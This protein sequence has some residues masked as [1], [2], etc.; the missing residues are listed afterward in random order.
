MVSTIQ[1]PEIDNGAIPTMKA[2]FGLLCKYKTCTEEGICLR[3]HVQHIKIIKASSRDKVSAWICKQVRLKPACT[4]KE[5]RSEKD[6][7]L[8]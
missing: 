7:Q 8:A 6:F 5:T 2:Y 1:N 3:K 4:A